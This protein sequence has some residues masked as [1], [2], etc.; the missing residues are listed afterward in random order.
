M[1]HHSVFYDSSGRRSRWLLIGSVVAAAI[2]LGVVAI[3]LVSLLF[4]PAIST[5]PPATGE[6]R[7]SLAPPLAGLPTRANRLARFLEDRARRRL[8]QGIRTE[9]SAHRA[10][11]AA[12]REAAEAPTIVA[13]FYATWQ[14][15]GLHS[16]RA[17]SSRLT[18]LLPVWLH[19]SRD[20]ARLDYSDWDTLVTPHNRDVMRI[21]RGSGL[22]IMPVLSNG[23]G[24]SFDSVRVRLLLHRPA[25]QDTLVLQLREWLLAN[26]FQ[27]VNVD[28]ENLG[29]RDYKLLPAFLHRLKSGLASSALQVSV[30]V[31]AEE[32]PLD[33]VA[34]AA[35]CDFVVLMAYDQHYSGGPAGPIAAMGW[36]REVLRR[37]RAN[38][39]K[40]KLVVGIGNYA[41][42]WTAGRLP[43]ST[44]A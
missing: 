30:D 42:D 34:T 15:T 40:D 37:A 20:G 36:Y 8:F 7:H 17:N 25:S 3:F 21:A 5:S 24:E 44:H 18:H 39:P 10:R 4:V 9:E 27:G 33:W 23:T 16:L 12:G 28:F 6:P 22:A 1:A 13:A 29:P 35:A 14:E 38:I 26:H 2:L 19:L 31:E 32:A 43:S 41:Y 11:P